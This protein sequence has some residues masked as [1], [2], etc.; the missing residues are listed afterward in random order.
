MADEKYPRWRAR[1]DERVHDIDN[2]VKNWWE[3]TRAD[4][5]GADT[6]QQAAA[7]AW[8][9][10]KIAA[11][12]IGD[13]AAGRNDAETLAERASDVP[14]NWWA[15]LK[16]NVADWFDAK[17]DETRAEYNQAWKDEDYIGQRF[18]ERREELKKQGK[19]G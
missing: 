11:D 2:E 17:D 16:N 13:R 3:R 10:T 12:R 5:R 18:D 6:T 4:V 15:G 9:Q 14:R 19:L 7:G 8:D 1:W